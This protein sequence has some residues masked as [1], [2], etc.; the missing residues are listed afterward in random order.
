MV[1]L[2]KISGVANVSKSEFT[3]RSRQRSSFNITLRV[4]FNKSS[5]GRFVMWGG[6]TLNTAVLPEILIEETASA[7]MKMG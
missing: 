6:M 7:L 5:E 2:L 1:I 3:L 4:I